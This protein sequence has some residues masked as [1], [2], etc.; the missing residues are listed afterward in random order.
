MSAGVYP[1]K[2]GVSTKGGSDGGSGK[3]WPQ[4][5][6]RFHLQS[7]DGQ[8]VFGHTTGDQVRAKASRNLAKVSQSTSKIYFKHTNRRRLA[9]ASP[10][11]K[12]NFGPGRVRRHIAR[13]IRKMISRSE[14]G[15]SKRK[16]Q[17][18]LD[19]KFKRNN[20]DDHNFRALASQKTVRNPFL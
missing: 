4:D 14:E 1:A 13:R 3:R 12:K 15:V 9:S 10:K 18:T 16:F 5:G 19:V 7:P 8:Y 2:T 6:D 20:V 17:V 11:K